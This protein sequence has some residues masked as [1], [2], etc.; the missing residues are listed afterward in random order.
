MLDEDSNIWTA[1]GD[2]QI[3]LFTN[4]NLLRCIKNNQVKEIQERCGLLTK[5]VETKLK[6]NIEED[7]YRII[8]RG[9]PKKYLITFVCFSPR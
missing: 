3:F 5:R 6:I 2:G 8:H 1:G 4:E 7:D 9:P